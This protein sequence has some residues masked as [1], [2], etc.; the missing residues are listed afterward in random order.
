MENYLNE[1]AKIKGALT[2]PCLLEF[3]ET[4]Y[5]SP[6]KN[7]TSTSNEKNQ[8]NEN[9]EEILEVFNDVIEPED[10][11]EEHSSDDDDEYI[12]KE[13]DPPSN[14]KKDESIENLRKNFD[15]SKYPSAKVLFPL[16]K[17]SKSVLKLSIGEEIRILSK[18]SE[19]WF[20]YNPSSKQAGYVPYNYVKLE[21]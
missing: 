9:E 17:I 10:Q 3:L 11:E 6:E 19:W 12:T 20:A 21:D 14:N 16:D 8:I 2:S 18:E 15:H 1:L 4:S 5:I 13:N 7:S